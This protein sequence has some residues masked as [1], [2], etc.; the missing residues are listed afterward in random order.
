MGLFDGIVRIVNGNI[1]HDG[2]DSGNPLKIGGKASITTPSNVASGDRVD[3]WFDEKGAMYVNSSPGY[4]WAYYYGGLS[5]AVVNN[6]DILFQRAVTPTWPLT[7]DI[8]TA[9]EA[10]DYFDTDDVLFNADPIWCYI[11]MG[12]SSYRNANIAIRNV[13]GVDVAITAFMIADNNNLLS[14][15]PLSANSFRYVGDVDG[16]HTVAT[17]GYFYI[18]LG[19]DGDDTATN[20]ICSSWICG[21]LL[22]RFVPASDP[23][24]GG[25]LLMTVMRSR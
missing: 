23:P 19:T 7:D 1:A 10:L 15:G 24:G 22:I 21:G 9:A 3:A 11:P 2:V 6:A 18:G 5:G 14:V 8:S 16:P 13:T 20:R 12:Q 17:S 25:H 4:R